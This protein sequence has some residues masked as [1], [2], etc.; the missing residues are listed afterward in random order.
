[1]TFASHCSAS[2]TLR[3]GGR[4]CRGRLLHCFGSGAGDAL[5]AETAAA[6]IV[7]SHTEFLTV[8]THD[9]ARRPTDLLDMPLGYAGLVVRDVADRIDVRQFEI[10]VN[11]NQ[12]LSTAEAIDRAQWGADVSGSRRIKLEVLNRGLTQPDNACVAD[13]ASTLLALG[14]EVLPLIIA[15]VVVAKE[16]ESAGCSCIRVLLSDIGSERG[17]E[18]PSAFAS[19]CE[20]LRIPVIAEGGIGSAEHLFA[21]MALGAQGALV[22]KALFTVRDPISL[23]ATLRRVCDVGRLVYL[24]GRDRK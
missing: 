8:Y 18:A 17:L 3:I 1:M 13:A 21:A 19:V 14:F 2:D 11:T 20:A 5:S 16:L 10:L 23:V 22:N 9:I 7:A 12:A 15:D 6:L 4:T 24:S